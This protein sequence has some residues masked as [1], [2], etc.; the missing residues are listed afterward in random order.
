[1]KNIRRVARFFGVLVLAVLIALLG[2][3]LR[4]QLAVGSWKKEMLSGGEKLNVLELIPTPPLP[5]ENGAVEV[6]MAAKQLAS[7]PSNVPPLLRFLNPQQAVVV[8]TLD[9]WE[10]EKSNGKGMLTNTW[11]DVDDELSSTRILLTQIVEAL[12]KPAFNSGVVY[13][14]GFSSFDVPWLTQLKKAGQW[15]TALCIADLRK[16]HAEQAFTSLT[17]LNS[18]THAQESEPLIISQLVRVAVAYSAFGT[19]WQSLQSDTFSDAQLK[20]LS[21]QWQDNHFVDAM[22]ASFQVERDMTIDQFRILRSSKSK[23]DE[24]IRGMTQVAAM[25]GTEDSLGADSFFVNYIQVPLWRAAYS[26]HDELRSLKTW[27]ERITEARSLQTNSWAAINYEQGE[28][29]DGFFSVLESDEPKDYGWYGK[30]RFLFSATTT[31]S[32]RAT[33]LRAV[34]ADAQ[35][36]LAIAAIALKRFHMATGRYPDNLS[37]LV[38]AYL[39]A[40][41]KDWMDGKPLR[42][43]LKPDGTF[44]LYSINEDGKDD[45]GDGSLMAKKPK[46]ISIWDG[47][48]AIWPE[49]TFVKKLTLPKGK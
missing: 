22:V 48:D 43:N 39:S 1:M 5:A 24:G 23:L 41:P 38:P 46:K 8:F 11:T 26:Y 49:A 47:R 12:Q 17:A 21:Q 45:G 13:T 36:E 4:G 32:A 35:K 33:L 10:S 37:A 44:Q 42:Y 14:N 29:R 6:I 7:V 40:V 9:A 16:G 15:L 3:R 28:P 27:Q 19:L 2:E 31:F 25:F 34:R 30:L 20:S 18:L